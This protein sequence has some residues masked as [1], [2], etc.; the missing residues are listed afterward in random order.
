MM[1]NMYKIAGENL[2]GTFHVAARAVARHALSIYGDHD[3]VMGTR[4][5]G[6]GLLA[7]SSV[8][9]CMDLA[10]IAQLATVQ[11]SLPMIHFFEGFRL[12][13]E[14]CFAGG[15]FF[16]YMSQ[17]TTFLWLFRSTLL[18]W[19]IPTLWPTSLTSMLSRVCFY[20]NVP[21]WKR[22]L[23]SDT[24]GFRDRALN[25]GHPHLTGSAQV[26]IRAKWH[27]ILLT[28]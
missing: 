8:Q 7:S 25:P 14:V 27:C 23:S 12:S 3:D 24:L 11:A 15:L 22:P 9:E 19:L 10:V 16:L 6:F 28:M 20:P 1:P 13:H 2:P 26:C 5:A 17:I 18:R 4:P 21:F